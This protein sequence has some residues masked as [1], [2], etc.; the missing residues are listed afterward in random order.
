MCIDLI[1]IIGLIKAQRNHYFFHKLQR[2]PTAPLVGRSAAFEGSY[3]QTYLLYKPD[4]NST[5]KVK[6]QAFFRYGNW[7]YGGFINLEESVQL[8][9]VSFISYFPL[10]TFSFLKLSTRLMEL[11]LDN[12][13]ALGASCIHTYISSCCLY[14]HVRPLP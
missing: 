7:C 4:R 3:T 13:A 8:V 10:A 11:R 6:R 5:N 9:E 12:Q 2:R 1:L 14:K